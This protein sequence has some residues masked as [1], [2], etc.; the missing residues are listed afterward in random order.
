MDLVRPSQ[1][2]SVEDSPSLKVHSFLSRKEISSLLWDVTYLR[3]LSFSPWR[4]V[5]RLPRWGS[6]LLLSLCPAEAAAAA[7]TAAAAFAEKWEEEREE[8]LHKFSF[9]FFLTETSRHC[10]TKKTMTVSR[11]CYYDSKKTQ[12]L[13]NCRRIGLVLLQQPNG[14]WG[15]GGAGGDSCREMGVSLSLSLSLSSQLK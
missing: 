10:P 9:L 11:A 3:H 13:P 15:E 2:W 1:M 14:F 7:A 4:D 6:Y 5:R 12:S 8:S